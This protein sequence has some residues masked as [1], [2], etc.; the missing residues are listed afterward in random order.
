VNLI[1]ERS[2]VIN[3]RVPGNVQEFGAQFIMALVGELID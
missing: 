2:V 3:S 1:Y